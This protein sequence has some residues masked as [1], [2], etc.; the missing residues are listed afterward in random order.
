MILADPEGSV[1]APLGRDRRDDA[2]GSWAV[3]GIGEDFVPPNADLSLVHEAYHDPRR[4]E[5]RDRARAAARRRACSPAPRPA[6]CSRRRCA[7]A[8]RRASP[9]RVVT[10]VCDSG[11]KYLSKVFNDV[12]GAG[13]LDPS[14]SATAP[15]ATSSSA[16]TARAP[17]SSCAR[18]TLC[19]RSSRAC[20][21]PTSRSCR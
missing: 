2:G 1:L 6:R 16:A 4:G 15:C 13:G 3:E 18:R 12:P 11:A 20:A 10:L 19:A 7:I 9:K 14:A 21:R 17:R 5:L 8:A